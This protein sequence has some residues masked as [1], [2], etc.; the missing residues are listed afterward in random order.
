VGWA[1]VDLDAQ[2]LTIAKAII[3]DGW[4]PVESD[5]KTEESAGTIGLDSLNVAVLREHR[6]RQRLEKEKLGDGWVETGKVFTQEDGT[7]LHPEKVSD[8]FRRICKAADLPPVN[9]RDLRHCAATL[10]HAGGGDIHSIK[11]TLRHADI[12]LTSNTYTS[13]LKEVDLEIAEKAAALVPR[14][15]KAVA[16]T[17]GHASVTQTAVI[18]SK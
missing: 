8:E 6:E 7:W 13:L 10:I 11:E 15:R 9:L 4:T 17:T 3:V 5:P 16:R 2:T 14:A 12:Q 1:D 18:Y